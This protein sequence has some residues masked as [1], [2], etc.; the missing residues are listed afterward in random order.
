MSKT[1]KASKLRFW[2]QFDSGIMLGNTSF[3]SPKIWV[4]ECAFGM[5]EICQLILLFS[6]FLLLF[7][8]STTLFGTIHGSHCT[9]SANFYLY[10]QYF[11]QKVFS[12]SKISGFQ[13]NPKCSNFIV[14]CHM[15]GKISMRCV[16]RNTLFQFF[17]FFY[18]WCSVMQ[19][20]SQM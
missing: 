8:D 19:L 14:I 11:Q 20:F 6:L 4:N 2:W 9:V 18:F 10:L 1:I 3:G 7:M 13:T 12:F 17:F 5:N 15:F 16:M